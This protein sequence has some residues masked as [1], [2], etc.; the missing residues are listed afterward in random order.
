MW[1]Q[2][3]GYSQF[4]ELGGGEHRGFLEGRRGWERRCFVRGF[5]VVWVVGG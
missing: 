3:E 1:E 2:G 5:E 4:G